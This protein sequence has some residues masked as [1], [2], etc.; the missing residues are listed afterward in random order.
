MVSRSFAVTVVAFVCAAGY[1]IIAAQGRPTILRTWDDQ[2]MT[3]IWQVAFRWKANA[4][5]AALQ[6]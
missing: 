6:R 2:G 4:A 1:A 3:R 5:A